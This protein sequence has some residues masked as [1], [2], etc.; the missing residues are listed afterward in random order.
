VY[1]T[2]TR[3]ALFIMLNYQPRFR[4]YNELDTSVS[5]SFLSPA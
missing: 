4:P 3:L 1:P 5:P 2:F